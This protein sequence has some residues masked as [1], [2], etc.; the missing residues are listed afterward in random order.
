MYQ[1][2]SLRFKLPLSVSGGFIT[3]FVPMLSFKIFF[4]ETA[5]SCKK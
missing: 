2:T 5:V 1:F 3:L 4:A